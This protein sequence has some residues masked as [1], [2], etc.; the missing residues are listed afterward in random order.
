MT[1][2]RR[3][4]TKAM[5]IDYI[6]TLFALSDIVSSMSGGVPTPHG[7]NIRAAIIALIRRSK[8]AGA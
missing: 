1:Q 2:P 5:M 6:K 4:I 8:G 7:L 3:K